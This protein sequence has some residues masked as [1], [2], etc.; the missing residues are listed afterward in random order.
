MNSYLL[1]C[2]ISANVRQSIQVKFNDLKLPASVVDTLEKN[3]T[4]SL[5]PNLSNALKAE[6][7]ALRV[8][9]RELYDSYCLHFGDNH[10]V[11]SNYFEEAN[12][13]IKFIRAQATV[14]NAK[15]FEL[16]EAEHSKWCET[17]EGFLH[18]LFSDETEYALAR[19]AYL[20]VFP[21]R[22][23]YRNPIRVHVVGPLP[24]SL[25]TV[26]EPVEGDIES[27]IAHENLINTKEVIEAAHAN[28]AD[29]ALLMSAELLDDLD[30]RTA[31]KIGRQQTGGDKKRG[32]WQITAQKLKLISD[33]VP[34]FDNLAAL[35]EKLLKAGESI[36][37][38]NRTV[39]EEGCQMFQQVQSDIRIELESIVSTRDSSKGLETL[40]KSLALSNNYKTLCEQLKTAE[41]VSVL[42]KLVSDANIELDIYAQRSKH[43]NKI[44]AQRRELFD[45]L[46]GTTT[47]KPV[48]EEQE[49]PEEAD[50]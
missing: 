3:N 7:D 10:F 36:Q 34:G 50:F 27:L 18:P 49:Q 46:N 21:T 16:W 30:V 40:Q 25:E 2:S 47:I 8:M 35:A 44:I 26:T 28:A 6:L 11:T 29:K 31:T 4:V 9:Q 33:S 43:I 19:E 13:L 38:I 45:A 37:A 17:V 1:S 41:T 12:N 20:K 48:E 5:R 39:R 22:Q 15:L 14:S 24:V 42:D 23:E 32:S